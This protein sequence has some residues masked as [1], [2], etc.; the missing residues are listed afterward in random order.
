M[1]DIEELAQ[2][3]KA[4]EAGLTSF[5]HKIG[6][7]RAVARALI[8]LGYGKGLAEERYTPTHRDCECTEPCQHPIES[9]L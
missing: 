2:S 6:Y 9:G 7:H 4:I 8:G 1:D 5:E 3:L